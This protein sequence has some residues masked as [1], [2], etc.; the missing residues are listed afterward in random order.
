[1]AVVLA[2]AIVAVVAWLY[3]GAQVQAPRIALVLL[4]LATGV[5]VKYHLRVQARRQGAP[6]AR[7]RGVV[8]FVVDLLLFALVVWVLLPR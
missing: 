4:L 8:E 2:F 7:R 1:M 5:A 6:A 3:L